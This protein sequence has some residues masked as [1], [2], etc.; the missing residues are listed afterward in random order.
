M[1]RLAGLAQRA[2][3]RPLA[4]LATPEPGRRSALRA[5]SVPGREHGDVHG[6]G[7]QQVLI[8]VV[9]EGRVRVV[10]QQHGDVVLSPGATVARLEV[11]VPLTVEALPQGPSELRLR[12]ELR[13][14]LD[15]YGDRLKVVVVRNKIASHHPAYIKLDPGRRPNPSRHG[16]GR[17]VE[18]G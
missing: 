2:V 10:A 17:L 3:G 5:H 4:S 8:E 6:S 14:P 15:G 13:V 11:D 9:V 1:Q 16:S 18:I 7:R 12:L